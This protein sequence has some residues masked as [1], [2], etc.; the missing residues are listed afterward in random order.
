MK[1]N[2]LRKN[3]LDCLDKIKDGF[4]YFKGIKKEFD[5]SNHLTTESI[6]T[7]ARQNENHNNFPDFFFNGGIIEHFEVTASDETRKG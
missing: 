1:N 3:E 5:N 2:N 4:I 7:S 6:L